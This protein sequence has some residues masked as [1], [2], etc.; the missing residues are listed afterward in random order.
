ME[1]LRILSATVLVA[2]SI[3]TIVQADD[4]APTERIV[5]P[6]HLDALF[7]TTSS[8]PV[9]Y[10]SIQPLLGRG[11]ISY[12]YPTIDSCRCASNGCFHPSRYYCGGKQYRKNWFRKWVKAH[13]GHGSMLDDYPC[14]CVIPTTGRS[15]RLNVRTSESS[16]DMVIPPVPSEAEPALA[17]SATDDNSR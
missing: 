4:P 5:A 13:L 8:S 1:S 17:P 9:E 15:H 10:E 2:S 16:S 7:R 3:V 14:H 6:T 12:S 11:Y